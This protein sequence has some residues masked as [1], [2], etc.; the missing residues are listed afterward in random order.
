MPPRPSGH[1]SDDELEYA[2]GND[3][4]GLSFVD[5]KSFAGIT[6]YPKTAAAGALLNRHPRRKTLDEEIR[7]AEDDG[8]FNSSVLIGVGT[9]SKKRGFLKG[10]GAAGTPVHMGVGYVIGAEESEDE[11]L[12]DNQADEVADDCLNL[13]TQN[14]DATVRAGD[15]SDEDEDE[16]LLARRPS[17]IPVRKGQVMKRSWLPVA[18]TT[19]TFTTGARGRG[20]GKR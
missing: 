7:V 4:R 5:E 3:D 6:P 12:S 14:S 1:P 2:S 19:T 17:S 20:R 11:Q 16:R 9:R 18:T 15:G 13:A 8:L 10:G